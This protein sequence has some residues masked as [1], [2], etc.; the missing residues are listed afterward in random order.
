[1]EKLDILKEMVELVNDNSSSS[2]E[3]LIAY[4]MESIEDFTNGLDMLEVMRMIHYGNFNPMQAL[5]RFNGYGNLESLSEYEYDEEI[6]DYENEIVEY[7]TYD[8]GD[9]HYLLEDLKSLK[10]FE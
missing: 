10:D 9:D 3:H 4:D 8:F 5:F 1:M 2:L 7:F 6:M